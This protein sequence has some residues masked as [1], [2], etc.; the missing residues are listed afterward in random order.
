MSTLSREQVAQ[1]LDTLHD[2][3]IGVT[4]RRSAHKALSDT[5]AALRDL[6]RQREEELTHYRTAALSVGETD[7]HGWAETTKEL[8]QR[9]E[10][11]K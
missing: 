2:D 8:R 9:L 6:L 11:A 5:D 3:G 4:T 7:G 10:S 1:A